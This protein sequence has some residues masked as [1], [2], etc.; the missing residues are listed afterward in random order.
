[1]YANQLEKRMFWTFG[2]ELIGAGLCAIEEEFRWDGM[3]F[4][5]SF[6]CGLDSIIADF[7]ERKIRRK[8]TL[9]FMQ[10]FIDEHTGEAG[11]DTRIEAFIEMI[12]KMCIRDR[13]MEDH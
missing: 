3:I 2:R 5:S 1:M 6:A 11:I 13:Y 7:I 10:L 8:G 9:P 4:L 12:E